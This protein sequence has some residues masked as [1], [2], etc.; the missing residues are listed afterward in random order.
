MEMQ[1]QKE[2]IIRLSAAKSESRNSGTQE[3]LNKLVGKYEAM[4]GKVDFAQIQ[5]LLTGTSTDW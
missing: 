4:K 1:T 2:T 3:K 5:M